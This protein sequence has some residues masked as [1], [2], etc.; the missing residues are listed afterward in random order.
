MLACRTIIGFGAPHK[1]G[2]SATHGSAL[3]EDEVAAARK[4]LG[5]EY[6]PFVVPDELLAKWRKAGAR[7][8]PVRREWQ[9]R[10][11]RA[12]NR[13]EFDHALS[14]KLPSGFA[15]AMGDY[16]KEL[17]QSPPTL[18][19]RNS[20]QNA[21]DVINEAVPVTIGGSADLTGSNNT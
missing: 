3:G 11:D 7:G 9:D 21:L 2:T 4:T 16:K 15:K 12:G 8:A 13:E 1:Q 10:H 18:A 6:P 14:G 17:A 19:T 20:S 5:W